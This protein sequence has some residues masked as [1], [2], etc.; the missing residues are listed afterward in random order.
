M[1]NREVAFDLYQRGYIDLQAGALQPAISAFQ[2]YIDSVSP[3]DSR[4]RS[5][6][7]HGTGQFAG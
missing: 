6:G 5:V 4:G 2:A 1:V 7:R 3:T